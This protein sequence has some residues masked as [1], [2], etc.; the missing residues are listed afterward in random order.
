MWPIIDEIPESDVYLLETP[1]IAMASPQGTPAQTNINVQLS[2]T[3]AMISLALAKRCGAI[4]LPTEEVSSEI[5][6]NSSKVLRTTE[7]DPKKSLASE[8]P[9][10]QLL[11][12]RQY[13]AAR[14]VFLLLSFIHR[15]FTDER[16]FRRLFQTVVGKERVSSETIISGLMENRLEMFKPETN[17]FIGAQLKVNNEFKSIYESAARYEKEYLGQSL[18]MA[19]AFIRLSVIQCPDSLAIIGRRAK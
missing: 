5:A 9:T 1:R 17:R 13:L 15:I 11:F 19:L 4:N 6:A 7:P 12:L 8:I 2:Q 10:K 16:L 14:Y 18:L 3:I